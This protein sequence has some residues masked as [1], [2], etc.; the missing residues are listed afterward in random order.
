M[1]EVAFVPVKGK[2]EI[3]EAASN[4]EAAAAQALIAYLNAPQ[5]RTWKQLAAAGCKIKRVEYAVDERQSDAFRQIGVLEGMR[6]AEDAAN[7]A[8]EG[9]SETALEAVK[10]VGARLGRFTVEELRNASVLEAP[11]DQRAWGGVIQRAARLGIIVR[12]GYSTSK[13]SNGAPVYVWRFVGYH[14]PSTTVESQQ[15]HAD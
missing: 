6:A 15:C 9:W 4:T 7:R 3:W 14:Q 11:T 13:T 12:D 2:H 5:V 1:N 8:V 10:E